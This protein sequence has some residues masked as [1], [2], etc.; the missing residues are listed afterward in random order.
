M[1]RGKVK[2][3]VEKDAK[4]FHF[5]VI[6]YKWINVYTSNLKIEQILLSFGMG[7]ISSAKA[8]ELFRF[9]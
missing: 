9:E 4:S 5:W 3:E 8:I 1:K 6:N 2:G 7:H